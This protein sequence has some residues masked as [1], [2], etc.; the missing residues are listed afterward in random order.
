[1]APSLL[2]VKQTHRR[3]VDL[4]AGIKGLV[5]LPITVV[6]LLVFVFFILGFMNQ[7]PLFSISW[8]GYNIAV[9]PYADQGFVGI[10]PFLPFL[11]YT[12]IHVN[13]FEEYYFRTNSKRVVI[14]AFLHMVMGVSVGVALMLLPL[15]FFYKYI[16]DKY[17]VDYAYAL[18][19]STNITILSISAISFIVMSYG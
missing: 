18:H 7:F 3:I 19:F 13:Y 4:K 14:W 5:F 17:G 15:G 9:G 11:V 10:I 2:F 12:F 1:M 8:L 6:L 16:Y